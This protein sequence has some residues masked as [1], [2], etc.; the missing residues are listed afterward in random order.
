[1]CFHSCWFS[2]SPKGVQG[3]EQKWGT[4]CSM[5]KLSR[6]VLIVRYFQ[7]LISW[8]QF[9]YLLIFRKALKSLVLMIIRNTLQKNVSVIA[10]IPPSP[11]SHV[12]WPPCCPAP[13]Y[14]LPLWSSFLGLSAVLIL[15]QIKLNSNLSNCTFFKV[16]I[17]KCYQHGKA[18]ICL[19]NRCSSH[20]VNHLPPLWSSW[21]LPLSA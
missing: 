1:M 4:L 15:P 6:Q 12:Y 2:T 5:E 16:N 20:L 19:P 17:T 11:K 10:R 8:A 18:N 7:E 14:F 21:P 9:L 3:R 13:P